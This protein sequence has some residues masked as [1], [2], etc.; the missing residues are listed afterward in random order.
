[1]LNPRIQ[2]LVRKTGSFEEAFIDRM[3]SMSTKREQ[4]DY[5]AEGL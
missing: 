3:F 1:M 5:L 2:Y 4:I